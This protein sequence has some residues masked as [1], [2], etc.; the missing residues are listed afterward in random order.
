MSKK[1][2][3]EKES[4]F[5][6]DAIFFKAQALSYNRLKRKSELCGALYNLNVFKSALVI[7]QVAF[8]NFSLLF[9]PNFV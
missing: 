7:L 4:T 9:S 6:S 1:T 8:Q 2:K 5:K 3:E